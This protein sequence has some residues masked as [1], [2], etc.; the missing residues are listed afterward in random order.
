MYQRA[1]MLASN[2]VGAKPQQSVDRDIEVP[3]SVVD[4]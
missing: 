1:P 4:A 3:R 2:I